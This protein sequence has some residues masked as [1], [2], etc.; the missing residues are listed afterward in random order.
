[1]KQGLVI[2]IKGLAIVIIAIIGIVVTL[3]GTLYILNA[4]HKLND[5]AKAFLNHYIVGEMDF[6]N[7]Y[8]DLK[9]FP[10]INLTAENGLL[11]SHLYKF[12]TDTL[13]TFD[14]LEVL[15]EVDKLWAD[16]LTISIPHVKV[17]NGFTLVTISENGVPGWNIWRFRAPKPKPKVKKIPPQ[18][19]WIDEVQLCGKNRFIYYNHYRKRIMHLEADSVYVKGSVQIRANNIYFDTINIQNGVAN[20]SLENGETLIQGRTPRITLSSV[21]DD[22]LRYY[23]IHTEVSDTKFQ[24]LNSLIFNNGDSVGV[25]GTVGFNPFTGHYASKGAN[26]TVNKT[27]NIS[28]MGR[29]NSRNDSIDIGLAISTPSVMA[30]AQ[31]FELDTLSIFKTINPINLA[32]HSQLQMVGTLNFN[33]ITTLPPLGATVRLSNGA[34]GVSNLGIF[35]NLYANLATTVNLNNSTVIDTL[36]IYGL[37]FKYRNSILNSCDGIIYMGGVNKPIADIN[38]DVAIDIADFDKYI[39]DNLQLAGVASMDASLFC[40][41]YKGADKSE[42]NIIFNDS[43]KFSN[44][45]FIIPNSNAQLICNSGNIFI[46]SNPDLA[47]LNLYGLS[48]NSYEEM[49]ISIEELEAMVAFNPSQMEIKGELS[50]YQNNCA[51]YSLDT[52]SINNISSNF[53]IDLDSITAPIVNYSTLIDNARYANADSSLILLENLDITANAS[54]YKIVDFSKDIKYKIWELIGDW[55]YSGTLH[56]DSVRGIAPQLPLISVI[57]KGDLEFNQDSLRLNELDISIGNSYSN[58]SGIINNWRNYIAKDSLLT[59]RAKLESE[60]VM[61]NELIPAIVDGGIYAQSHNGGKQ[62]QRN[63]FLEVP[64]NL[65]VELK[66]SIINTNYNNITADSAYF[67]ISIKDKGFY[68]DNFKASTDF[69]RLAVSFS[70]ITMDSDSANLSLHFDVEKFNASELLAQAPKISETIPLLSSFKGKFET[71]LD[72]TWVIDKDMDIVE[73][74]IYTTANLRGEELSLSR[75]AVIP[76]WLGWLLLGRDKD[77]TIDTLDLDLTIN[78]ELL[79]LHPTS[80]NLNDKYFIDANGVAS[81]SAYR[82]HL[83]VKDSPLWFQLAFNLF[84]KGDKLKLKLAKLESETLNDMS[85]MLDTPASKQKLYDPTNLHKF[86]IKVERKGLKENYKNSYNAVNDIK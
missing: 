65:D 81:I 10:T 73:P 75:S 49:D 59:I 78:D 7:L 42:G 74:S 52:L 5:T 64:N 72:A 6:E 31:E 68:L 47:Q 13:A 76:N 50:L 9:Q 26:I 70:Y 41:L 24:F 34:L 84:N 4:N 33:D 14:K 45:T 82:Y 27:T 79:L 40:P 60:H 36:Q 16:S 55:K 58:L 66:S 83:L 85:Q 11:I 23:T 80:L 86:D 53:S 30:M 48:L 44:L 3:L 63:H 20:I 39:P 18:R 54:L 35:E 29:Y 67:N 15:I 12:P 43:L 51:F 57:R 2:I 69:L 1:M 8:L 38:F 46:E 71:T 17:T 77:I 32:L 37:N 28:L 19:L 62:E 61:L 56:I 22:S 21:I 25:N